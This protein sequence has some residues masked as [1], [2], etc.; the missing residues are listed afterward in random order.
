M[1]A[2]RDQ[3]LYFEAYY[4]E[5]KVGKTGLTVTVD[6]WKKV[7]GSAASE[8]VTGASATEVGDGLYGYELAAA[9]NDANRATYTAVFKTATTSVDRQELAARF[10]VDH[11]F[12]AS[13]EAGTATF[14]SA[15]E[16][17]TLTA[18]LHRTWDFPNVAAG[19]DLDGYESL[20]FAVQKDVFTGTDDTAV[21]RVQSGSNGLKRIGG[22]V[23]VDDT[24]GTLTYSGPSFSVLIADSETD[25][26]GLAVGRYTWQLIGSDTTPTPDETDPI[27]EGTFVIKASTY[28]G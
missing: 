23:A 27:A 5:S 1:L 2:R 21:L 15:V 16:G 17:S 11:T 4:V 26:S 14:V 24:L 9:S 6:I 25:A 3:A 19:T 7:P 10:D 12:L 18:Y 8:I 22:A 13:V 20:V 28:I